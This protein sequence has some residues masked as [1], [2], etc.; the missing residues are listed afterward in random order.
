MLNS[1]SIATQEYVQ[2]MISQAIGQILASAYW[3]RLADKWGFTGFHNAI[4][5]V[6]V[7]WRPL[8]CCYPII[9]QII[10]N[11]DFLVG[12]RAIEW[13]VTLKS[14][15]RSWSTEVKNFTTTASPESITTD[16][17]YIFWKNYAFY[18][19]AMLKGVCTHICDVV[20]KI[21]WFRL[22]YVWYA[23]CWTIR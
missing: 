20:P 10:W 9:I 23:K 7:R 1:K 16:V 5:D 11:Y 6:V 21:D 22:I 8:A 12:W 4:Y 15:N 3:F 17:C 14:W 2:L 19:A 13:C 18:T